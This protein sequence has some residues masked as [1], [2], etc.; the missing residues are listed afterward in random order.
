MYIKR[1]GKSL[2][3]VISGKLYKVVGMEDKMVVFLDME[4][5]EQKARI[6]KNWT[7]F[8][9]ELNITDIASGEKKAIEKAVER[10]VT[11]QKQPTK[12]VNNYNQSSGSD[13]TNLAIGMAIGGALF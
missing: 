2:S 3:T 1:T 5:I 13:F 4:G 8:Q 7:V 10:E 6:G 9:G 12:V 11:K